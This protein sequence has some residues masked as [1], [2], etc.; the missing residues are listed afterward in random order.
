[1]LGLLGHIKLFARPFWTTKLSQL[2]A[3]QEIGIMYH[4]RTVST[5]RDGSDPRVKKQITPYHCIPPLNT[6]MLVADL[7][8]N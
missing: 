8:S 5:I 6:R 3:A 1:M 2:S 7:G 4:V